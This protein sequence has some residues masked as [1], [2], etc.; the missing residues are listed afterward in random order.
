[1]SQKRVNSIKVNTLGWNWFK[2]KKSGQLLAIDK[3][4]EEWADIRI[5]FMDADNVTSGHYK[6]RVKLSHCVTTVINS[7][8]NQPTQQ[9]KQYRVIQSNR[10]KAL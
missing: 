7:G 8:K 9:V 4:G 2:F 5:N 1:M 3:D 10:I 6:A